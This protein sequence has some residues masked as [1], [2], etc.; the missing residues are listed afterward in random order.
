MKRLLE[1]ITTDDSLENDLQISFME[2]NLESVSLIS[3]MN[4]Q[5]PKG[6]EYV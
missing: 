1:E 5:S 2:Q 3:T 4:E 6:A